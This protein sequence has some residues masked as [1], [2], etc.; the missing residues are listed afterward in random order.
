MLR[1][2]GLHLINPKKGRGPSTHFVTNEKELLGLA[3]GA[4]LPPRYACTLAPSSSVTKTAS[5][6]GVFAIQPVD[7]LRCERV[8][9]LTVGCNQLFSISAMASR[10]SCW[11]LSK[12]FHN[13]SANLVGHG[14]D[15]L[16][17][18][19]RGDKV[20]STHSCL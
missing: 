8:L 4:G 14:R 9:E 18:R 16:L 5:G 10:P 1:Q 13:W 12:S 19:A 11:N 6:H 2:K 7:Y 17:E 15:R 20:R 3:H